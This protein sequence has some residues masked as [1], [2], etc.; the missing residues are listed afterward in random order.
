VKFLL[1]ADSYFFRGV[2]GQLPSLKDSSDNFYIFV[3]YILKI[4]EKTDNLKKK[5]QDTS[6]TTK[7]TR[8]TVIILTK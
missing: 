6:Y 7:S 4:H 8:G 1:W 5:D 3:A 2:S